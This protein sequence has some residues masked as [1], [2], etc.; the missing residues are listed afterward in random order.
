[1]G[2]P[3]GS[4]LSR[5]P[6]GVI[7]RMAFVCPFG[8]F[9]LEAGNGHSQNYSDACRECP[10]KALCV[11]GAN[12][13]ECLPGT[14]SIGSGQGLTNFPFPS[15]HFSNVI[16]DPPSTNKVSDLSFFFESSVSDCDNSV[17]G[18]YRTEV[19]GPKRTFQSTRKRQVNPVHFGSGHPL[20]LS[21]HNMVCKRE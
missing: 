2:V 13:P 7:T 5:L 17:S 19:F 1:M 9:N 4:L 20:D 8:T 14:Y 12:T 3:A 18:L 10:E 21:Y 16:P 15:R 11:G 6:S